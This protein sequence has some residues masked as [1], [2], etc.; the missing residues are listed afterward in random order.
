MSLSQDLFPAPSPL[1]CSL[2]AP[3]FVFSSHDD[4]RRLASPR[5]LMSV[6]TVSGDSPSLSRVTPSSAWPWPWPRHPGPP[7]LTLTLTHQPP[8]RAVTSCDPGAP[9]TGHCTLA[10]SLVTPLKML[11]CSPQLPA[12]NSA[13][14]IAFSG[15]TFKYQ[16]PQ[17]NYRPATVSFKFRIRRD[18]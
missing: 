12:R 14:T 2:S 6:M 5:A 11:S 16:Q 15:L 13:P 9:H 1:L 7:P 17:R 8:R 10:W 18:K 3:H 4:G